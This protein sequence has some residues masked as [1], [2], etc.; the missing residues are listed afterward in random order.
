MWCPLH[1]SH[2]TLKL[3]DASWPCHT[4]SQKPWLPLGLGHFCG[5]WALLQLWWIICPSVFCGTS[6]FAA[7]ACSHLEPGAW[8]W[9]GVGVSS[10]S[11]GWSPPGLASPCTSSCYTL[12]HL[13][14]CPTRSQEPWG[15]A[16]CQA[17]WSS[18]SLRGQGPVALLLRFETGRRGHYRADGPIKGGVNPSGNGLNIPW[19]FSAIKLF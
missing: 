16:P 3:E 9:G 1:T 5:L 12:S 6:C 19:M 2:L 7:A 11:L 15:L 14:C 4:L 13:A 18:T 8:Q 10:T 17:I